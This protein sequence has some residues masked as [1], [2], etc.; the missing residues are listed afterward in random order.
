MHKHLTAADRSTLGMMLRSG[1]SQTD[2]ADTIGAHRSTITR[3][4]N[5]NGRSD[6][7]YHAA[8]A[9]VKARGRRHTAKY[10]SRKI[11]NDPDLRR[12]LERSL[13]PLT[14]PETVAHE[15]GIHHQT[16]YTWIYRSRPEI[17]RQ[18]PYQ[19][20]KRRKYGSKRAKKQGWTQHVRPIG[21]VPQN[22]PVWEGDTIKGGDRA[23][24]LTHVETESL[25]T[26]L[27][28]LPDG[29]AD[30][31]QGALKSETCFQDTALLYDRGS[32]F[33]LWRMIEDDT[34]A[35][36]FFADPHAPWQRGKNENQNGRLRRVF[37]KR[38]PLSTI[39]PG[40]LKRVEWKMNHTPRKSLF[41]RT[42][43]EVYGKCCVSG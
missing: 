27:H 6:G 18:L 8:T 35:V 34:G 43:C 36:T 22:L 41:W 33:A 24:V 2:I 42:P 16:I 11:E 1:Y 4:L 28:P 38:L 37:P 10:S 17:R 21:D 3:E 9:R 15:Y 7:T 30:S 13:D 20:K 32:E 23:R 12:A 29:T 26:L 40:E 25:Y 19:G 5:R 14:S 39:T 31:V